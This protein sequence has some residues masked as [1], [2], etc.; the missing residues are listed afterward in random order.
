MH[1]EGQDNYSPSTVAAL[2]LA[3][4]LSQASQTDWGEVVRQSQ[5]EAVQGA[6][7]QVDRIAAELGEALARILLLDDQH[8]LLKAPSG[9]EHEDLRGEHERLERLLGD[10]VRASVQHARVE[11]L[12]QVELMRGIG[13]LASG[14]IYLAGS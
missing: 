12:L 4:L 6:S 10:Y 5:K 8:A 14:S 7:D 2:V 13:G 1:T 9:A 11:A 3:D